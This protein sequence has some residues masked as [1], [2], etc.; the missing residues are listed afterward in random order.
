MLEGKIE[1]Y[2]V[3][4]LQK[5][6]LL[7][8][9]APLDQPQ[10]SA[11]LSGTTIPL[12]LP[13]QIKL[14]E[15][16]LAEPLPPHGL[17]L[18]AAQSATRWLL[19]HLA[20]KPKQQHIVVLCGPGN[21]G[22]DGALIAAALQAAG[23]AVQ[24]IKVEAFEQEGN[25]KP[26]D[27]AFAWQ[28]SPLRKV[29][30]MPQEAP[31]YNHRMFSQSL[32]HHDVI[33]DALFGI[34]QK[35]APT[36]VTQALLDWANHQAAVRV[37]I[38]LPTGLNP[39]NGQLFEGASGAAFKAAF[40]LSFI[41]PTVGVATGQGLHY[42]G[43]VF[44]DSLSHTALMPNIESVESTP[45][46]NLLVSPNLPLFATL[47][48]IAGSHK[49]SHGSLVVVGG[50]KGMEGA[51]LLAGRSAI[52]G[53]AGKVWLASLSDNNA[54]VLVEPALMSV[55]ANPKA[56]APLF[57]SQHPS[58]VLIGPGLGQ[59][60][61]AQKL[62]S[63]VLSITIET[64]PSAL[65]VDAD[66]LNAVASDKKLAKLLRGYAGAKVLTPHP[67]EAARLLG[68][69]TEQVQQDRLGSAQ[70]IAK[71]F[72]AVVVLKGSGTVVAD[73]Q[74][75]SWVLPVGNPLLATAGTGDV[76]AGLIGALMAQGLLAGD[77]ALGAVTCHGLAAS[78]AARDLPA[79]IGLSAS[80]LIAPMRAVL[81][82]LVSAQ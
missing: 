63:A 1:L 29:L 14:I 10:G 70:Q 36:Q 80:E 71:L 43:Q 53:G 15:A 79:F 44:L 54:S 5:N 32:T 35:R 74:M 51:L 37:A 81:N 65:I 50:S 78:H 21:N 39:V 30:A 68:V 28:H 66:A 45:K 67:L 31:F 62:L 46:P 24:V 69:T 42:C 38:D 47:Q 76:L 59:S 55:E 27:A 26:S 60:K 17:M 18:R 72:Q 58:A 57:S 12:L 33:I 77:A 56:L 20:L 23:F 16:A 13:S 64:P 3:T 75:A 48:R 6:T 19:A 7:I 9:I 34:G 22:G 61:E 25:L 73:P 52:A 2:A 11:A 82:Q 4:P 41:A 8:R 49:G 40:T